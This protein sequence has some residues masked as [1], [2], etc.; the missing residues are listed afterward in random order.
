MIIKID[1]NYV[2]TSILDKE[3]TIYQQLLKSFLNV[4]LFGYPRLFD[5]F[6]LDF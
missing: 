3:T 6:F 5:C 1:L 4:T 2:F